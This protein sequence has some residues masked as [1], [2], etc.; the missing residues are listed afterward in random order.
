MSGNR[1]LYVPI[2]TRGTRERRQERPPSGGRLRALRTRDFQGC[3]SGKEGAVIRAAAS[4][5]RKTTDRRGTR[6]KS[7]GCS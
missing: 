6:S 7:L 1:S 4:E 5:S 2:G 3:S